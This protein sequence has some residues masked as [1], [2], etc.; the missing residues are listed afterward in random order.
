MKMEFCSGK[1]PEIHVKLNIL[2]GRK[3]RHVRMWATEID[4][5]V[6]SALDFRTRGAGLDAR[7]RPFYLFFPRIAVSCDQQS[8]PRAETLFV[9]CHS[10]NTYRLNFSQNRT[11]NFNKWLFDNSGR[12]SE[13]ADWIQL[14]EG[15]VQWWSLWTCAMN[16]GVLWKAGNFFTN[17]VTV[18]VSGGNFIYGVW[19][20]WKLFRGVWFKRNFFHGVCFK[21]NLFHAVWFSMV[22]IIFP[23]IYIALPYED[24]CCL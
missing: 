12:R 5:L 6:L 1:D 4:G 20:K 11:S 8:S 22:E 13:G 23:F 15:W 16:V 10:G 24:S 7:R 14:A 18:G 21:R 2:P 17:W 19:F 9:A 3:P